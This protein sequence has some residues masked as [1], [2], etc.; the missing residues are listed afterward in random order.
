M[1]SSSGATAAPEL[2]A[3]AYH[4]HPEREDTLGGLAVG[5]ADICGLT[6]DPEQALALDSI[7]STSR[8]PESGEERF[9]H[10]EACIIQSRQNGKTG[11]VLL[12]IALLA[13]I[14]RPDQ[15]I[16][17]SAHRT[18]TSKEAFLALLK[19]YRRV[20]EIHR[21]VS[22]PVFSNGEEA[23]EFHNGSRIVFV[24]RSQASGRG[25]SG[26]L[27]ILDEALFLTSEMMGALMPTLSARPDPLVV[28][29]SSAGLATSAV[30]H[31]VKNRGRA[32]GDPSLV[33]VEW[34]APEGSCREKDCD[35][36]R[37]RNGCAADD[38]AMWRL[39]NPALGRRI[40]ERYV[41]AER[42]SLD[43]V[44][45]TRERLGWWQ[46]LGTGGL[47]HM[48]TWWKRQDSST[49]PGPKITM[50]LHVTPDRGHAAVGVASRRGDGKLHVELIEHRDGV[51]WSVPYMVDRAE[52]HR[53][54]AVVAAGSMAAGA[55]VPE[56]E[57]IARF[58]PLPSSEVKRACARFYDLVAEGAV[59]VR[60]H[61]ALD[62]AVDLAKKST[63]RGEWVFDADDGGDV[64]ALYA[65]ALAAWAAAEKPYDPL[66]HI[67]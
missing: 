5:L 2:V 57:R 27:V 50:A 60:P 20:P 12:P 43:P 53:P 42:R 55:L 14:R 45:F 6:L 59:A 52:K 62:A 56:L 66:K 17:W 24:A 1:S 39:A 61:P 48:P 3:P 34:C 49:T 8:D 65:V 21:R 25:L 19:I 31:D 38:P 35:H 10:L 51:S 22:K 44:E 9:A 36:A 15:L 13:A 58:R 4:W 46:E 47:F 64:S 18:K 37:D 33:Y 54:S 30:L 28:Y 40:T 23:F 26:D 32:G 7:L 41:A 67:Y 16:V 29:A 11:G 63:E